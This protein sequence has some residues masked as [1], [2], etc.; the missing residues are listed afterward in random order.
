LAFLLVLQISYGQEWSIALSP[1]NVDCVT[2]TAC[3]NVLM[4]ATGSDFELGSSNLRV[5]YNA[6]TQKYLKGTGAISVNK[7]YQITN[8]KLKNQTA[9]LAGKGSLSFD[10][11]MGLLDIP[12]DFYGDKALIINTQSFSVL[13]SNICFESSNKQSIAKPSDFVWV[14]SETKEQYT[15]AE[16]TINNVEGASTDLQSSTFITQKAETRSDCGTTELLVSASNYPNPFSEVTKVAYT[17][18]HDARVSLDVFTMDGKR[19][20]QQEN[21]KRAGSHHFLVNKDQLAG[22]GVYIY[23]IQT[24]NNSIEARMILM[25]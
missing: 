12:I 5:F 2:R 8:D 20:H 22:A 7:G 23:R 4:K 19:V 11:N 16:T 25:K 14:S 15:T 3:Y 6:S 17:I 21:N 18:Q 1:V 24:S 13:A 9:S 10:E